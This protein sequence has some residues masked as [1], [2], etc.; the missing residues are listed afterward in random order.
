ML[1]KGACADPELMRKVKNLLADTLLIWGRLDGIVPPTTWG[2]P[3]RRAPRA[4][5]DVI[6]RCGH[7]PMVEKS[8]MFHRILYDDLAGVEEKI[9]DVVKV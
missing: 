1:V 2:S 6:D 9:P 8:E 7:L 4:R 3:S 5:L